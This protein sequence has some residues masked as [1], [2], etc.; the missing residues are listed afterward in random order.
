MKILYWQNISARG[1]AFQRLLSWP[2]LSFTP[3]I[4]IPISD[5]NAISIMGIGEFFDPYFSEDVMCFCIKVCDEVHPGG[6][7]SDLAKYLRK[8]GMDNATSIVSH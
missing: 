3:V 4:K 5:P 6:D 7:L 2:H 1:K 8:G